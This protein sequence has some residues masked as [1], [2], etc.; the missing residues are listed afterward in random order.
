MIRVRAEKAGDAPA[1]RRVLE[2]AFGG[3]AEADLVEDLR[4]A[5]VASPSLVALEG[6]EIV[7]F[8]AFSPV[9]LVGSGPVEGALGLAPMA[10]RPGQQRQGIGSELVKGGL[11][12]AL[13]L[14][15]RIV[16]VLGHPEYYPRFG[17]LPAERWGITCEFPSPPECFL[18]LELAA[19]A[20]QSL[21]GTVEYHS[22]FKR[23]W[24]GPP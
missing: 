2:A 1:V 5:G 23:D 4:R 24:G 20:A 18:A 19:G 12:A 6:E 17:F 7:G 11:E 13:E 10:V 22:A 9:G 3:S 8:I 14:G 16:V 21:R 15:A